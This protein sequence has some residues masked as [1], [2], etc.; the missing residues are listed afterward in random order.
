MQTD[1]NGFSLWGEEHGNKTVL[2]AF[3]NDL[4]SF[5]CGNNCDNHHLLVPFFV[6]T[7]VLIWNSQ[8]SQKMEIASVL[9]LKK[10]SL[11]EVEKF[12]SL[13]LRK[14]YAP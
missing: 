8:Q 5:S 14:T 7:S 10:Q 9:Q 1:L 12:M 13:Y 2:M 4:H 3:D 11:L 6:P